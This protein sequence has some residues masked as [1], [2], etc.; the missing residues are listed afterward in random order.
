MAYSTVSSWAK[1]M[2]AK[3]FKDCPTEGAKAIAEWF[4]VVA[5]KTQ[6]PNDAGSVNQFFHCCGGREIGGF[7]RIISVF[8]D[9]LRI[10]GERT[11]DNRQYYIDLYNKNVKR[12]DMQA[13]RKT[14]M[15]K[16]ILTQISGATGL[17]TIVA[18]TTEYEDQLLAGEALRE[19]GFKD[20]LRKRN[21]NSDNMVTTW[22][23]VGDGTL[24]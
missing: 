6:Y 14:A 11:H 1:P 3:P 19:L 18:T 22:L 15:K 24:L 7:S 4:K 16:G 20:V 13:I 8:F 5:E 10:L 23:Y 9:K 2:P 17:C 21:S 12:D